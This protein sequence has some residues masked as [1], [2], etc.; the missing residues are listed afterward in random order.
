VFRLA[1]IFTI[2]ATIIPTA[3]LS[4]IV[5]RVYTF[6][7]GS[8]LT[9]SQLN[10]EFNNLVD[11]VNSITDDNITSGA[12][13]SPAKISSTIAGAGIT[14]DGTSGALSVVVDNSTVEFSGLTL[15]QKD[16]GTTTAKLANSGVTTA[17][18]ADLNVTE[19]K[20]ANSAVS[21]NKIAANAVA[22]VNILDQ[23][24]TT[25]KLENEGVTS[26][27]I[28]PNAIVTAQI[29]DSSVTNAKINNGEIAGTKLV[30]SIDL[31]GNSAKENGKN[32][33]VS[34]TNASTSLAII[35]GISPAAGGSPAA[36][37]GEGF[38]TTRN[39]IGNYTVAF[40]TAFA[41]TPAVTA[42]VVGGFIPVAIT[43]V[44]TTGF[45]YQTG[46]TSLST[47]LSDRALSFTAVGAR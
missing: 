19:G 36:G 22:T 26:A 20:I 34:S 21:L 45:T 37:E 7:D 12:A 32:L 24:V 11:G 38:S 15:R 39:S 46:T 33:V 31:P 8:V 43:A 47:T 10:T 28:A 13:I 29:V 30:S 3:A 27:K 9:A 16:L 40:T 6:T 2:G 4:A 1:A 41:D 5:S 25:A 44:S 35:R 23:N 18:I 14:R 17:K 42:N